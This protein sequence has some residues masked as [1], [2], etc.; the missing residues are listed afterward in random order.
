M[1][2]FL[3]TT[4][5]AAFIGAFAFY[6]I[7]NSVGSDLGSADNAIELFSFLISMLPTSVV[8]PFMEGNFTQIT[9]LAGSFL[10]I[11]A[12]PVAGGMI[13]AYAVVMMMLGIPADSIVLI[14]SLSMFVDFVGSAVNITSTECVLLLSASREGLVDRK[15]LLRI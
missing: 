2:R 6:L 12:P 7:F 3:L 15:K 9:V 13:T 1:G 10:M 8:R 14:T 11:S 4:L 5:I